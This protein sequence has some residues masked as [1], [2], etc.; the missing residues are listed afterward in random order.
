MSANF[1]RSQESNMSAGLDATLEMPRVS[2]PVDTARPATLAGAF[3]ELGVSNADEWGWD[4]YERVIRHLIQRFGARQL[5][6]IGGGRAP[7]FGLPE[8]ADLDV[9]LTVNDISAPEL[10]RLPAGYL[11][12]C[13]NVAGELPEILRNEYDFAFSRMVFEHVEDGR[14]AWRNLH[15]VLAPGGVAIAFI[16]TLFAFPFVINW[17]IPD[18]IAKRIAEMLDRGR[19]DDTVPVFPAHYSW[20]F[21]IERWL[22]PMLS[23]AGYREVMVLPFYGHRYYQHFPIVRDV[24]AWFTA[25]ARRKDWRIFSTYTYIVVRK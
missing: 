19:S 17:L 20:S 1:V 18:R 23:E 5:L 2:A 11:T 8:L 6:E 10:A 15:S 24:H 22:R 14:Q 9:A 3:A 16:P 21:S 12:A 4:N 7:M 13:F 25:L